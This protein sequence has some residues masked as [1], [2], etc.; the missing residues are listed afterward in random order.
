MPDIYHCKHQP[1]LG[2]GI[3]VPGGAQGSR[4]CGP[5]TIQMALDAATRGELVPS[6]QE[7]RKR[8]GKPGPQTTNTFDA[9]RCVESYGGSDMFK[10]DR[11]GLDYDRF[12]GSTFLP[13]LTDAVRAG[14]PIQLAIDYGRFNR[15]MRRKTG[16]PAF[17]GGHSV[18]VHGWKRSGSGQQWYLFDPLDD[19]RRPGIPTGPR[20]VPKDALISAWRS[21]GCFFGIIRGG[22]R[23]L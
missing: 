18:L 17:D 23:T 15:E 22:E 4:D 20:W 21:F 13:L 7:I 2:R 16:D 11:R 10:L 12:T 14:E 3:P 9:D 8:M 6:I 1:Q 5:R 19:G